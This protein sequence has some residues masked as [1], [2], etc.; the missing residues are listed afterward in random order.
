MELREK[1]LK[2]VFTPVRNRVI[3][4]VSW[5]M[6]LG[7]VRCCWFEL[8]MREELTRRDQILW[9][10]MESSLKDLIDLIEVVGFLLLSS[11]SWN[12]KIRVDKL[13]VMVCISPFSFEA[14]SAI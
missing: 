3:I 4:F 2:V 13:M 7:K 11:L 9:E 8:R 5:L 12:L 6:E 10:S 1:G 14:Y